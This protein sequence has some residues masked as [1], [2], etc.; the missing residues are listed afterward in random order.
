MTI[1]ILKDFGIELTKEQK[2]EMLALPTEEKVDR[3]KMNLIKQIF[4]T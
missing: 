1:S 3:Y 2:K 4:N